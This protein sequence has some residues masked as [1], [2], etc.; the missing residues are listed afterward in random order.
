MS[1]AALPRRQELPVSIDTPVRTTSGRRAGPTSNRDALAGQA[2]AGVLAKGR[3][4]ELP[5]EP[6]RLLDTATYEG[7]T[8]TCCT[9]RW[10]RCRCHRCRA[11]SPS[12]RGGDGDRDVLTG[13]RV[14]ESFPAAGV[15][16]GAGNAAVL[17]A[18]SDGVS[19]TGAADRCAGI[20]AP[21]W[22]TSSVSSW[23]WCPSLLDAGADLL[24]AADAV[25]DLVAALCPPGQTWRA[26]DRLWRRPAVAGDDA[27]GWQMS[28]WSSP[29]TAAGSRDHRGPAYATEA[30]TPP[31]NWPVRSPPAW[32]T[33]RLLIEAD[34]PVADALRQISFR[35]AADD[36]QFLTIAKV[37]TARE[38]WAASPMRW[39]HCGAATIHAV[40]SLTDDDPARPWVNMLR[41]PAA[42]G[43]GR[44]GH[45]RGEPFDVAI[46]GAGAGMSVGFAAGSPATPTAAARESHLGCSIRRGF[47]DFV[48]DLTEPLPTSPGRISRASRPPAGSAARSS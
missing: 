5:A 19:G 26:F 32:P 40:S 31:W 37:R 14:M 28:S 20:P 38:L 46:P 39:G 27:P 1:P 10:T 41:T 21:T 47:L 8:S 17:G 13:W 30:P 42:F 23:N 11:P 7:L 29:S 12:A 18:L 35:F 9:P 44:G 34:L 24:V 15:A 33:M 45:R 6:E 3:T 25:L 4:G 48:E 36:D 16:A 2:V 43:A 22:A